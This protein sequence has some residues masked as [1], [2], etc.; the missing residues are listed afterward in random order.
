MVEVT[1]ISQ[2][3][4][5]TRSHGDKIFEYEFHTRTSN[6]PIKM[7]FLLDKTFWL[8]VFRAWVQNSYSKV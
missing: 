6:R 2:W 3:V 5:A 1:T 8:D 7:L 4:M